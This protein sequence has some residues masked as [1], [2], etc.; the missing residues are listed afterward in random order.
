MNEIDLKYDIFK[1]NNMRYSDYHIDSYNN[2]IALLKIGTGKVIIFDIKTNE[3]KEVNLGYALT[4]IKF[5]KSNNFELICGSG[6][7]RT[8][9]IILV[10][11]QNEIKIKEIILDTVPYFYFFMEILF[12][13]SFSPD[14]K[15]LAY[16]EKN[17]L[18]NSKM[19]IYKILDTREEQSYIRKEQSFDVPLKKI[20]T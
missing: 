20:R 6:H 16:I 9:T 17:S 11:F 14:G 15:K 19:H 10:N 3:I 1:H 12:N 5:N 2:K 8:N 18:E 13:A 7:T 4:D